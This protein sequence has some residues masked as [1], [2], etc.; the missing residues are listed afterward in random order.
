[1]MYV[2]E[3]VECT[4]LIKEGKQEEAKK[5]IRDFD[6]E[7]LFKT[8]ETEVTPKECQ[9][10][11]TG[12]EYVFFAALSKV[13]DGYIEFRG[14][15]GTLWKIEL[16]N[17][18]VVDYSGEVVYRRIGSVSIP[19]EIFREGVI[20][21]ERYIAVIFDSEVIAYDR[22]ARKWV[23]SLFYGSLGDLQLLDSIVQGRDV[24]NF[25][26]PQQVKLDQEIFDRFVRKILEA[27]LDP[28]VKEDVKK[29]VLA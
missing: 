16:E 4:L 23:S 18:E 19:E 1:M 3:I 24:K 2:V 9:F 10:N 17:G 22:K 11:W 29:E 26:L 28:E 14:E 15:D 5:I 8:S 25:Y 20:V 12:S 6:M 21:N 7:W 13:A 27:N